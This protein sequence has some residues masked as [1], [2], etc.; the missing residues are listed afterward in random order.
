MRE[1]KQEIVSHQTVRHVAHLA[2]LAMQEEDLE[3]FS[4]Q[5]NDILSYFTKIDNVNTDGVSGTFYP[6]PLANVYRDDLE[7]ESLPVEDTLANA[8]L[9]EKG[10]FKMPKIID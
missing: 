2:R 1:T 10:F 5:L 6:L 4:L 9:R 7:K 8:P 3:K